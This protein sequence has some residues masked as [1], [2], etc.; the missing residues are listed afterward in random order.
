M[1]AMAKEVYIVRHGES[2]SNAD[3]VHRG[4]APSLT[5]EGRQQAAFV[6]ERIKAIGVDALVTSPWPRALQ[7]AGFI[8]EATG[9]VP[10]ESN[11]FVERRRPSS[12]I[13]KRHDSPEMRQM[14]KEMFDGYLIPGHRYADEENLDDLRARSH[15]A[16]EFLRNH[17]KERIA[18]V[19]H[20]F[21]MC[22]L[23]C[24][25]L[26]PEFTGRQF[27]AAT[28]G[29]GFSNAGVAHFSLQ[30]PYR[31]AGEERWKVV[32]WNDVAHLG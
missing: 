16:L 17:P 18:V 26:D 8:A 32:S 14:V 5:D 1:R 30:P 6:A 4:P 7:T 13:G 15:G 22:V 23:F 25:A 12:A 28:K 9:L 2:E 11:L 10:E 29:L 20:G 27:Q 31:Q 24:Q 19:S 21:F 3:G